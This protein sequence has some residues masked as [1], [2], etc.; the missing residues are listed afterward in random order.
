MLSQKKD[1]E[2]T[3]DAVTF[4]GADSSQVHADIK[5]SRLET[6]TQIKTPIKTYTNTNGVI[7]LTILAIERNNNALRFISA[8]KK[9]IL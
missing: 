9:Q 1:I 3:L 5:I 2:E 6:K 7:R 4:H 8:R